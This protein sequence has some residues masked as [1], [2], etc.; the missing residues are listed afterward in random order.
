VIR[1]TLSIK[2]KPGREAEFERVWQTVAERVRTEPGNVR[3]TL[4]RDPADPSGYVIASDWESRDAFTRF[5]RSPAQDAL[6]APIR[7]LRAS[8]SMTVQEIVTHLDGGKAVA[9]GP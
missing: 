7:E 3:Q 6:T 1:A 4:L 8:A 5:E 2:V 9:D